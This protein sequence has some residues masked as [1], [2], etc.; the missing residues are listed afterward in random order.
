MLKINIISVKIQEDNLILLWLFICLFRCFLNILNIILF[1][2]R[3]L[4]MILFLFK[5]P[6]LSNIMSL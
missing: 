5:N 3:K 2:S 1:V 6:C 4:I